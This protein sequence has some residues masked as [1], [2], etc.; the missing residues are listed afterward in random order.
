MYHFNSGGLL[1]VACNSKKTGQALNNVRVLIVRLYVMTLTV[2]SSRTFVRAGH[3][4]R[5]MY[6]ET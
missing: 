1:S 2:I 4:T 5:V 3:T 6:Q